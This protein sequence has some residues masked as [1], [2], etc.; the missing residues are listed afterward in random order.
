MCVT[1]RFRLGDHGRYPPF[2]NDKPELEQSLDQRFELLSHLILIEKIYET[3]FRNNCN[4]T[5]DRADGRK[6]RWLSRLDEHAP[7]IRLGDVHTLYRVWLEMGKH[8][9]CREYKLL[10]R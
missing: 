9:A 10:N 7:T 2:R 8:A 4:F 5:R 3:C 1:T 6:F